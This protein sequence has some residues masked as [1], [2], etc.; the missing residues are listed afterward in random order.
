MQNLEGA[1]KL[2]D[3]LGVTDQQFYEAIQSYEGAEKRNN[4][5]QA[6]DSS[7][8][9]SD[10]AHA[11][12]K[13]K[14]TVHAVNELHPDRKLTACF[15]LHTFSSL[16]KEYLPNY[17]DKMKYADTAIVYYNKATLEAKGD[18]VL[19]TDEL[20]AFFNEKNLLVFTDSDE[21]KN[22]LNKQNWKNHDLLMMSSGNFGGLNLSEL[23]DN[24]LS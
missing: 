3:L 16:N 5:V 7:A 24:L 4:L 20:K 19:S 11:P 21:L 10:F 9:Y 17:A 23:A 13:V 6:N 22:Y 18:T 12:S 15:E 1:R 8:I 14:A 2:L